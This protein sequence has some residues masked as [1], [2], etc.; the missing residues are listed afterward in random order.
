VEL[1]LQG[2]AASDAI[3]QRFPRMVLINRRQIYL[4]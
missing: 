3:G 4:R 2:G 1:V